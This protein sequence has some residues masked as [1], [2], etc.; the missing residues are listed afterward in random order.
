MLNFL[1]KDFQ[2]YFFILF[3]GILP[4]TKYFIPHLTFS[5]VV[6]ATFSIRR[7][8]SDSYKFIG[9]VYLPMFIILLGI[10]GLLY[11]SDVNE[12]MFFLEKKLSILFI[13]LIIFFIT[14]K[15]RLQLNSILKA[16]IL[17]NFL[18]SIICLILAVKKSLVIG[19]EG[20]LIF[21]PS[22]WPTVTE[23]F[24]FFKL[25]AYRYSNFS[26]SFLSVFHHPSY[27]SIYILFSIVSI[28][29]FIKWEKN[30]KPIYYLLIFYFSVFLWLLSSRAAYVTY[31]T[32]FL[33]LIVILILK[34]QKYWIGFIM[35]LL[36]ITVSTIALSNKQL[37]ENMK[38][39]IHLAEGKELNEDSDMRLW[40]WKSGLEVFNEN[41]LFGVGTGDIK[42]ELKK[43]YEK[44][45][46]SLASEHN[47]N[48][49]NQY[50]DI[51]VRLGIVGLILFLSW[52]LYTL[53]VTIKN[54]QF[55][56]FFF[57]L[58][59]LVNFFF[60]VVLNSI[61]GVSFFVFFYC[62]LYAKYNIRDD[63]ELI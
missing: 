49:H 58:I 3:V 15:V 57:M 6:S 5:L 21:E 19:E 45:K 41:I 22:H 30:Y 14:D 24:S 54:K 34:H 55:L 13:P 9:L 26:H 62:L 7:I 42:A 46:L 56:F 31:L 61:A 8:N 29:Y 12:G 35:I 2:F 16:F 36:G 11:S 47:Y 18:A 60:E 43:K 38:E 20:N 4:F 44:Y 51:G 53:Y 32:G 40:L 1:R 27:F 28:I 63:L 48:L 37:R 52:I 23:G 10:I 25:I 59:M 17:A 39:S 50:L 33:V